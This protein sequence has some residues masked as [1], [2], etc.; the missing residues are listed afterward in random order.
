MSADPAPRKD[1]YAP[2]K[3]DEALAVPGRNPLHT[4]FFGVLFLLTVVGLPLTIGGLAGLL[5]APL[6][7][8]GLWWLYR[9][10]TPRGPREPPVSETSGAAT[11]PRCGSMQ[12]DRRRFLASEDPDE[13]RWQCFACEHRW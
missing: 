5:A 13:P 3:H 12:T 7:G 10:T 8:G 1:A 11:C 6:V 2:P 9:V 4:S